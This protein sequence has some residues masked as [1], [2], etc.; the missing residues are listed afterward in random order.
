MTARLKLDF[1]LIVS[2]VAALERIERCLGELR[3]ELAGAKGVKLAG[4]RRRRGAFEVLFR[5]DPPFCPAGCD[6]SNDPGEPGPL[7]GDDGV[8]LAR[9]AEVIR[10]EASQ[11]RRAIS[12]VAP[13]RGTVRRPAPPD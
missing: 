12:E 8:I 1:A 3:K 7:P 11:L 10:S 9:F 2:W 13:A 5:S 6:G 4:D